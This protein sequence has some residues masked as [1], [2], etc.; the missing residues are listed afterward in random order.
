M[1]R[2]Q[3]AALERQKAQMTTRN[4]DDPSMARLSEM[5]AKESQ[6]DRLEMERDLARKIYEEVANSYESARLLVAGRSS[7]LQ[8][9]TRAI[10][11]DKPESRKIP[12][13]VLIGALSGFL[14]ASLLVLVR[15][16]I[17]EPAAVGS[18]VAAVRGQL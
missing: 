1:S 6:L 5:Y 9:L 12:R 16:N 15:G 7:G 10:P 3:L 17:A 14:L 13:N 2:T 11:P 18:R 8:I 4:L